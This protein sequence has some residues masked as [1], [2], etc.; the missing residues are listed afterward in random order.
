MTLR[1][2]RELADSR[3]EFVS[4]FRGQKFYLAS[5]EAQAKFDAD[6]TRYAPV[7][8]GADVVVLVNHED[9]VEGSLDFAAWYKGRLY[10]FGSRETHDTFVANPQKF[11]KPRGIE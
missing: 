11:A 2:D 4:S 10:L 6:P 1:D 3:P 5:K 8:Y 9:V 7:A